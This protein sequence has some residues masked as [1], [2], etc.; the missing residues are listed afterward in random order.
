MLPT[1]EPPVLCKGSVAGDDAELEWVDGEFLVEQQVGPWME[2]PLWVGPEEGNFMRAS[3]ER[4]LGNGLRIR[5]L[6][7]TVVDTLE[8]ARVA[9]PRTTRPPE[10]RARRNSACSTPG[11]RTSRR[12]QCRG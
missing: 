7:K 6:E 10:W 1:L 9:K 2:L 5:M 8:W 4:A 3:V 11:G 12:K